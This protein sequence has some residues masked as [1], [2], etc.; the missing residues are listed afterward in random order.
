MILVTVDTVVMSGTYTLMI[1]RKNDPFKNYWALPGGF[2]N[3]DEAPLD[4]ALREL[5]EETGLTILE[6]SRREIFQIGAFGKPGRDPR[7]HVVSIAY[8]ILLLKPLPEVKGA[9]DALEAAWFSTRRPDH[10][11]DLEIAFDHRNIIEQAFRRIEDSFDGPH[12]IE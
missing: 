3:E 7:G 6:A 11:S 9:D 5:Q 10:L 1:R 4:G 8:A 12:P 2:L